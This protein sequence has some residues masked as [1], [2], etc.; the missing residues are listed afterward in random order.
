LAFIWWK[1]SKAFISARFGCVI[2]HHLLG[3]ITQALV[4]GH[5]AE[6]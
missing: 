2:F 3:H 1:V 5:S 4:E 6:G